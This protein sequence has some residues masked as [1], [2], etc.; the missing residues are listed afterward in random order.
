VAQVLLQVSQ[1]VVADRQHLWHGQLAL[2]KVTGKTDES[3]VLVAAGADAADN[4]TAIG[5]GQA[6]ILAIAARPC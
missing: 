4:R 2:C 3:V 1:F 6:D 5:G